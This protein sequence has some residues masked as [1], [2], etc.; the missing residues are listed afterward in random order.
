MTGYEYMVEAYMKLSAFLFQL[1]WTFLHHLLRNEVMTFDA[2]LHG[3]KD[4]KSLAQDFYLIVFD[5]IKLIITKAV[6]TVDVEAGAADSEFEDEASSK[7]PLL[8]FISKYHYKTLESRET[9]LLSL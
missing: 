7:T 9:F 2:M 6:A 4:L 8:E 3:F 5:W 1:D